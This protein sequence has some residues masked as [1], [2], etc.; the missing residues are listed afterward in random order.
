MTQN[1]NVT[2]KQL[3]ALVGVAGSGSIAAAARLLNLTAP[4][5]HNQI[6]LLED[7]LGVALLERGADHTGS[8]LT[9]AGQVLLRTADRIDAILS[10]GLHQISELQ[11]GRLGRITLGVVSTA[12]YFAPS[13]V[14]TL[15]LLHPE[16]TLIL[17]VG[18]R[19]SILRG[20][21]TGTLDLAIMGRPPRDPPVEAIP[22][23]PHPHSILA[24]PDHPLAGRAALSWADLREETFLTREEGSGTRILMERY[25]DQLGDGEAYPTEEMGS[26]ETIKQAVMAGLGIAFLS[27]HT[28][29]SELRHRS[30]IILQTPNT[31]V[32]R[33]WFLVHAAHRRLEPAVQRIH[34][35]IHRL[36]GSFLPDLPSR[37]ASRAMSA[38]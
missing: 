12:K 3:R 22:L 11:R 20:I 24:A 14:K 21:G 16:V 10:Q 17:D 2:L 9:P 19:D 36:D 18:N 13:L 27:L 26:N 30:L 8:R 15:K 32:E 31:P 1:S 7:S 37:P 28:V 38:L 4:A 6:K 25:L 23:G 33:H 34:D 5:V 35:A 29:V